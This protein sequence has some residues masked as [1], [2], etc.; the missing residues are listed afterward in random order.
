MAGSVAV[1]DPRHNR[2]MDPLRGKLLLATPPLTDPNFLRTVILVVEHTD[3]GALGLVLNRPTEA[4]VAE[5]AP[6]LTE[7]G[8]PDAVVFEGGP[9]QPNGLIVLAEFGDPEAAAIL[10]HADIGVLAAGTELERTVADVGRTRVFAGH[11][12]WGPGQ[13]D[14]ELEAEGWLVADPERSEILSD[15]PEELW[16]AVLTR[17]GGQFAL[18]ARMPLDPSL[19]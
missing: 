4:L 2:W 3:E 15:E 6:E 13:L 7:L 14:A 11:A 18:V 17:M 19:N 16:S 10:V 1:R 8:E 9:V 12:G 5:A